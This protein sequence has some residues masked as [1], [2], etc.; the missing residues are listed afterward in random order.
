[1]TISSGFFMLIN[2]L[3]I[4]IMGFSIW[5][6]YKNGLVSQVLSFCSFLIALFAGFLLGPVLANH[7]ALFSDSTS[8]INAIT[9]VFL[10]EIVWFLIV[11]VIVKIIVDI[12]V[13]L[14]SIISH[15]PLIGTVN[16]ILGAV[17]GA[18]IGVVWVLII[19]IILS[20]PVFDNG[21]EVREKTLIKPLSDVTDK[22]IIYASENVDFAKLQEQF[23]FSD[24]DIDSWRQSID[25]WLDDKGAFTNE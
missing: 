20:T 21:L 12:I 11:T 14:S 8:S 24:A 1:M 22:V 6:G 18:V 2:I 10:N 4:A 23:G 5:G 9:S 13:N 25:Q 17:A 16:K 3:V 19:S 7:I 15:I